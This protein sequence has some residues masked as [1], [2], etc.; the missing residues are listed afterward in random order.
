M[1]NP[2]RLRDVLYR[3][4][5]A[6]RKRGDKER[7]GYHDALI[8]QLDHGMNTPGQI[9]LMMQQPTPERKAFGPIKTDWQRA[10]SWGT[11]GGCA[12]SSARKQ[13][14]QQLKGGM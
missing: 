5:R 10:Q 2:K 4:R 3:R 14:R 1:V 13:K 11:K 12:A 9:L 8:K 6:A 7:Q